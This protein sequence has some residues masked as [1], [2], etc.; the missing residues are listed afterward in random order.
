MRTKS[1][2]MI[3]NHVQ[4]VTFYLY[5]VMVSRIHIKLAPIFFNGS[6][7]YQ[8]RLATHQIKTWKVYSYETIK[9]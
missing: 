1:L 8:N 2:L 4:M 9:L 5:K 6:F 3:A 7:D